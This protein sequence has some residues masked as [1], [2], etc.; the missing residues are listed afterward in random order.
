M[1]KKHGTK[2]SKNITKQLMLMTNG[3]PLI[4]L[5]R[6]T[7]TTV[8]SMRWKLRVSK[9]KLSL[10]LDVDNVPLAKS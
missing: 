7:V 10:R 9:E 5:C 4:F 8:P 3:V 2:T 6:D 1:N